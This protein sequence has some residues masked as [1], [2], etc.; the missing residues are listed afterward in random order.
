MATEGPFLRDGGQCIAAGNYGNNQSLPGN[1]GSGQFLAVYLSAARTVALATVQG[2]RI[3]GILQNKPALGDAADVC[4]LG[5]SKAFCGATVAAGAIL[6]VNSSA[7]VITWTAGTG[8]FQIGQALEAG[9]NGQIITIDVWFPNT[10]V[11]T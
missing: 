4:L 11:L 3:R 7:E 10:A 9:V 5:I 8:L 2:Q 6:M 1:G